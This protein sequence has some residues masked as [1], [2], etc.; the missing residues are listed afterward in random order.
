[1][2]DQGGNYGYR[3]DNH[4]DNYG[5]RMDDQGNMATRWTIDSGVLI[6]LSVVAMG[7][8]MTWCHY[9]REIVT[10]RSVV[11]HSN[12]RQSIKDSN[13]KIRKE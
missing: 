7:N 4:G 8:D 12:C 6:T 10:E 3:M 9:Y 2:D 11:S 13:D 5:Y 1:M